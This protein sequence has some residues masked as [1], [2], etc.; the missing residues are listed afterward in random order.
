MSWWDELDAAVGVVLDE[1]VGEPAIW[2][3][4]S[5]LEGD[6]Y[7]QSSFGPD[8]DRPVSDPFPARVTWAP[9][10]QA[11]GVKQEEGQVAT[12]SVMVDVARAYFAPYG[13]EPRQFDRFELL[14][15]QYQPGGHWLSVE[16]VADDD[17]ASIV[18]YCSVSRP[19]GA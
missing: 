2:H 3:P 12:F 11:I 13:S 19:V 6:E 9:T 10:T 16:R 7:T 14:E 18:Y 5:R 15:P 8:P 1:R 17:S 4:V